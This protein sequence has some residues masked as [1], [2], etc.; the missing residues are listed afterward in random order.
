MAPR[1]S[2]TS[3]PSS[4]HP[5]GNQCGPWIL[6]ALYCHVFVGHGNLCRG[7]KV[8]CLGLV[9]TQP[10]PWELVTSLG[11][12]HEDVS[13]TISA[14]CGPPSYSHPEGNLLSPSL[15]LQLEGHLLLSSCTPRHRALSLSLGLYRT[16]VLFTPTSYSFLHAQWSPLPQN[17]FFSNLQEKEHKTCLMEEEDK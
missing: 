10:F 15:H 5:H 4:C 14:N 3:G 7:W 2:R 6:V 1:T 9:H 12:W 8:W 11:C 17:R 13:R 16:E